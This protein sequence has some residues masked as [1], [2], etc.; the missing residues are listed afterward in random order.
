M[1]KEGIP[2]LV[3]Q[4]LKDSKKRDKEIEDLLFPLNLKLK[5]IFTNSQVSSAFY[6]T[7]THPPTH[8]YDE[9]DSISPL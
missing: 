5:G 6:S 2:L 9:K 8:K 3:L 7:K 4:P 1:K